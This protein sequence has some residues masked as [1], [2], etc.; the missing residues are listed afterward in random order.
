MVNIMDKKDTMDCFFY[1][2]CGHNRRCNPM[3]IW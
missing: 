1:G 2:L 3:W